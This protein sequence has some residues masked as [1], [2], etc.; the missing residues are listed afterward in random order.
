MCSL[1]FSKVLLYGKLIGNGNCRCGCCF[2]PQFNCE[3]G[4]GA[5]IEAC[6]LEIIYLL[7]FGLIVE[8]LVAF[9][10]IAY[11]VIKG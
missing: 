3:N 10:L 5:M 6:L 2:Y 7:L 4:G 1:D 9:T 11:I 8:A